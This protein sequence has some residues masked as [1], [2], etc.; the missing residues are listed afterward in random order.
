V[1]RSKPPR[2]V[3]IEEAN[4]ISTLKEKRTI[5]NPTRKGSP[6]YL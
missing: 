6:D 1:S 2:E 5:Q 4:K 3:G